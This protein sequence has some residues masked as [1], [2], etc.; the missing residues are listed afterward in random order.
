MKKARLKRRVFKYVTFLVNLAI[1]V[2]TSLVVN[3]FYL[4]QVFSTTLD[5]LKLPVQMK[6]PEKKDAF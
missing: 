3:M 5:K 6:F 2:N 1:N 4:V